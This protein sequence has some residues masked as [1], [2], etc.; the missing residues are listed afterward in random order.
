MGRIKQPA[1][2][3]RVARRAREEVAYIPF[4]IPSR[5]KLMKLEPKNLRQQE[6]LQYLQ[7]RPVVFL[8]G[9][10]GTGKSLL[11]A[12]RAASQLD[13][14]AIR[15]LFL[16]RP[17]VSVGKSI[18]LLPGEIEEKLGPYFAQTVAHLEKFL[19]PG[20]LSYHLEN[21]S[22]EMKPVEYLRGMSFE[23]C[24]VIL[25]EAQNFTHEEMEMCLTRLGENCQLIFTG[26]AKQNDL[27]TESGIVTTVKL[28]NRMLQDHPSYMTRSDIDKL[29]AGFGIVEFKPEDVVRSGLTRA[30]TKMYY[31]ND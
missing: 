27:K 1:R 18:G 10:A 17:A 7:E 8:T 25:E 9:S 14:K 3:G 4:E 29:D 28:V 30:L 19:G 31:H 12:H 16:V 11:A 22:I 5:P 23:N 26:D 6:A 24:I 2:K 21:K 20:A 13:S 15:K